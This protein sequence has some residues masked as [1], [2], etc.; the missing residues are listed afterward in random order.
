M[1][2]GRIGD[3]EGQAF[4]ADAVAVGDAD[5]HDVR[6]G[7]LAHDGEAFRA[8]AERLEPGDVV[9]VEMGVDGLD[10]AQV[11][12]AQELDVAVDALEHGIDDQRLAAMPAR[13]QIGVGA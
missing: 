8:L 11:E 13:Q 5:R 7:L 6:L 4:D 10:Q 2:P 12:L 1:W 9:G 3:V